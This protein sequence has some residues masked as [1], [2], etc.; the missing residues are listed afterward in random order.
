MHYDIVSII[1]F[2]HFGFI[3]KSLYRIIDEENEEL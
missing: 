1:K 2:I 3:V